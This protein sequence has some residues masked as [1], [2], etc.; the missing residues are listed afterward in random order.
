[1]YYMGTNQPADQ[2][3]IEELKGTLCIWLQCCAFDYI[4]AGLLR[5]IYT[6]TAT[7]TY[8]RWIRFSLNITCCWWQR[9]IYVINDVCKLYSLP[10]LTSMISS[11][12]MM[13]GILC[14]LQ[15]L[16][17]S[18][19]FFFG[20]RITR[21][22]SQYNVWWIVTR[23]SIYYVV[24]YY[25]RTSPD[26]AVLPGWFFSYVTCAVPRRKNRG[27]HQSWGA[28]DNEKEQCYCYSVVAE[29]FS[30]VSW[31]FA[32]RVTWCPVKV[33]KLVWATI[34]YRLQRCFAWNF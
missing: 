22:S 30:S 9:C 29:D 17:F 8:I 23:I 15:A 34:S 1:M 5:S 18:L 10:S 3:E 16:H 25:A 12:F 6:R 2:R 14:R 27:G 26:P 31:N 13:S 32:T 19:Y 7:C 28:S 11:F 20:L 4:L 33:T 21:N 24:N